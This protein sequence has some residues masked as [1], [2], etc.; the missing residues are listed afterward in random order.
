[1]LPE[2]EVDDYSWARPNPTA[3][4]A[5]GI[6]GVCRYLWRGGK[7]ITRTEMQDILGAGMFLVLGFEA[8]K[9]DHL[10]GAP[11]GVEDGKMARDLMDELGPETA[12]L[13]IYY[14]C[15]EQVIGQQAHDITVSYLTAADSASHASRCYA[16]FSVGE[17][18][19]RP[20]WQT[21]AWSNRLIS[22][23]AVLYQW[24]IEQQFQ[25]SAVD[26][27]DLRD[28]VNLGAV[29]PA[30][31]TPQ[32]SGTVI[33]PTQPSRGF[34]MALTDAQQAEMLA[35]VRALATNQGLNAGQQ[36]H[37]FNLVT[38]TSQIVN[39]VWTSQTSSTAAEAAQIGA[40]MAELK[41]IEAA[42]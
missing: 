18:Y 38:S 12:G 36:Q 40:V 5:S 23:L 10:L 41:K 21:V 13:P 15:D 27:N 32:G 3:L 4:A 39:R 42:A 14:A 19:G 8:N 33:R 6:K 7:G 2:L 34:L 1:M 25:G 26:Y 20:F 11:K 24:A 30:G 31:H 9:G 35:K 28:A 37:M 29:W 22:A 16:Q 17:A